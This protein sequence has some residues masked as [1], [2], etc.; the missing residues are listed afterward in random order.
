VGTLN[1]T[2]LGGG[3]QHSPAPLTGGWG[4]AVWASSFGRHWNRR[5]RA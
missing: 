2:P 5:C 3:L 1:Q 4:L